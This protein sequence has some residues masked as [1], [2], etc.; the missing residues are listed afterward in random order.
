MHCVLLGVY[1][2]LLNRH[3]QLLTSSDKQELENVVTEISGR[4]EVVSHGCQ[5]VDRLKKLSIGLK[6]S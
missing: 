6:N 5:P 4:I 1:A 3:L 2:S